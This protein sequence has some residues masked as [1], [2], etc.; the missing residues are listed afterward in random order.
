LPG[1]FFFDFLVYTL[2]FVSSDR[3]KPPVQFIVKNIQI[4]HAIVGEMFGGGRQ[5]AVGLQAPHKG[6]RQPDDPFPLVAES[7][8][9][10]DLALTVL[11]LFQS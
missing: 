10:G 5:P 2:H 4:I 1:S 6:S 9:F 3:L 8:N 7:A 11:F